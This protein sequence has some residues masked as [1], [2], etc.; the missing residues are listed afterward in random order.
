LVLRDFDLE[1]CYAY[2]PFAFIFDSERD[3]FKRKISRQLYLHMA[4]P[5]ETCKKVRIIPEKHKNDHSRQTVITNRL[6]SGRETD[7]CQLISDAL[8][9]C[10]GI[11]VVIGRTPP[12]E[13]YHLKDFHS[14]EIPTRN[15]VEWTRAFHE[16]NW[17]RVPIVG[18]KQRRHRPTDQ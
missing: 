17:N 1:L 15:V 4:E 16:P 7:G 2:R 18:Q 3:I 14:Q 9:N 13:R 6:P 12:K 8:D 11:I 10:T 5:Y